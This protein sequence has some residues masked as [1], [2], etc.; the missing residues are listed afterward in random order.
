MKTQRLLLAIFLAFGGLFSMTPA[1]TAHQVCAD[2]RIVIYEGPNKT[3]DSIAVCSTKTDLNNL[4]HTQAGNCDPGDPFSKNNWD[5]C[6]SSYMITANVHAY[7]IGFWSNPLGL[8]Q[9]P[10]VEG[11]FIG[12]GLNWSNMSETSGD[13]EDNV[14]SGIQVGVN[15]APGGTCQTT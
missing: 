7:C 13:N 12:G 9:A 5:D 11:G 2:F 10:K 15:D 1:V 3:G 8:F 6:V 4:A 14:A